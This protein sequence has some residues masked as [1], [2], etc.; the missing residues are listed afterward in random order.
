MKVNQ[1]DRLLA[2]VEVLCAELKRP[3][4]SHDLLRYYSRHPDSRPLLF[5]RLGQLLLKLAR[6][7]TYSRPRIR[8]VGIIRN[9]AFYVPNDEREWGVAF[10]LH[11]SHIAITEQCR[12]RL[13]DYAMQ[14][15][16]TR[17]DAMA[18]NALA[19]YIEEWSP[20]I[21]LWHG[22]NDSILHKM[23]G[24][25]ATAKKYAS[26][27]FIRVAP[28]TFIGREEAAATLRKEYGKRM[29]GINAS[30]MSVGRHLVHLSWPQSRLFTP[31]PNLF[32]ADQV[33]AY[34]ASRWPVTPA[35]HEL[36]RG[37]SLVMIYGAI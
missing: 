3:V 28:E 8:R 22:S 15:L 4:C 36:G 9:L 23:R 20:V 29:P 12:F 2:D 16:G 1:F 7:R 33:K 10:E 31:L 17:F 18:R 25:L 5:Q 35:E 14:L 19:G 13:P 37:L 24:L 30:A 6:Q 21:D 26:P 11:R 27:E 34:S 32:W